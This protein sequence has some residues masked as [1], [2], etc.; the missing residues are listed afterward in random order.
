M[1]TGMERKPSQFIVYNE[2][3]EPISW[4]RY[5]PQIMIKTTNLPG[6]VAATV[7]PMNEQGDIYLDVIPEIVDHLVS[8]GVSG[9][10]IA[11]STG[12][13]MSLTDDERRAVAQAYVS[14]ARGKLKSVVQVGHNSMKASAELAAHAESLG[15][16]AVS[17]TP[18]GYFKPATEQELVDSLL[19]VAAAASATP[20]YYYHI[21]QLSGI[22]INP[23]KFTELAMER[24]ETF[25]GIKYSDGAT[26]YNLPKLQQ[27]A[28]DREFLA[29]SDEAYLESVALGYTGAVG[30]T[31]NYAAPIYRKVAEA[32]ANG[33]MDTARIWQ[34]RALQMI[35]IIFSTCG[36]A[37]LKA[38]MQ[39]VGIDC[40]PV[41]QPLKPAT[42]GQVADLRK[43]LEN[44]GWFDWIKHEKV[45]VA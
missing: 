37:G 29:G 24:M 31:Y 34:A 1:L 5:P 10:Y 6:L 39:M 11:G 36:R 28:P 23:V 19:P 9:I 44:I 32:M 38:M 22:A 41:R 45:R 18:P 35:D 16:D 4:N 30:S 21:P 2:D 40:G 13:G 7:T 42:K 25:A 15:A 12:E 33:D 26:L 17:A 27:V 43:Q 3:I 14:T 20:F 8:E